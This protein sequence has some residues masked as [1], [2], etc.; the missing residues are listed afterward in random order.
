[1][2]SKLYETRKAKG[3]SQAELAKRA[4]ITRVTV[5]NIETGKVKVVKSETLMKLAD[6]LDTTVGSL[7]F[8][9]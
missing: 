2:P 6:A 3:Y 4:G 7:F 9:E 5:S 1:M 8:G